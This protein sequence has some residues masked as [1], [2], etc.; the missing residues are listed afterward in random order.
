[1][2]RRQSSEEFDPFDEDL[3]GGDLE[4]VDLD[5][6]RLEVDNLAFDEEEDEAPDREPRPS[7]M[8]DLRRR[9]SAGRSSKPRSNRTRP[10]IRIVP[11]ILGFFQVILYAIIAL[12]LF[13]A[14]GFGIVFAGQQLGYIPARAST[15]ATAASAPTAVALVPT[16]AAQQPAAAPTQPAPPTATTD[17]GCPSA[18]NWWNSQQ[19]KDNYQY[20][21]QKALA[22]ALGSDRIPAL[23]EQ[24]SIRRDFVANF[25]LT[26]SDDPCLD[27]L[28]ADLLRGFDATIN[29]VR[30]YNTDSTGAATQQ[31]NADQAYADL[32]DALRT[33][34]VTVETATPA[35]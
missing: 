32:F 15:S 25:S 33:L 19:V 8:S 18:A 27:P 4:T 17:A 14:V 12:A 9:A 6:L 5:A 10:P 16:S 13:L 7:R 21:S 1:M 31:A 3:F 30:V 2:A 34:G 26:G 29:A 11:L 28:R 23:V 35:T 20:F 22:D 24:M